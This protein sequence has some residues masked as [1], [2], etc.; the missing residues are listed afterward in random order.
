MLKLRRVPLDQSTRRS[1]LMT[2]GVQV[3]HVSSRSLSSTPTAKVCLQVCNRKSWQS[4]GSP[5]LISLMRSVGTPTL[6]QLQQYDIVVPFS[7]SPFL[8]GV[9]LGNNLADYVDGGG[10]VVQYG[11]SHYGP[12]Q[13]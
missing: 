5:P 11:F 2:F 12:A 8:D 3:A 6:G 10:I 9:T 7:N 1:F 4:P 13:P